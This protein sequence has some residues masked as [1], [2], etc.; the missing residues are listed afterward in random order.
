[1]Y[2]NKAVATKMESCVKQSHI[3]VTHLHP[4][5]KLLE[6]KGGAAC[7][8]GF[9]SFLT[10]VIGWGFSTEPADFKSEIELIE[11]FYKTA[12]HFRVD[13]EIS[14]YVGHHLPIFLSQRGYKIT[15]L[16]N[17]S[18]LDLDDYCSKPLDT[19]HL[20]IREIKSSEIDEWAKRVAIG[21]GFP[22]AREQFALYVMAKGVTAF[23]VFD[24]DNI[25]A[26]A[27]IAMHGDICDL[28]VTSTLPIYRGQ[29][30]QKQLAITRLNYAKQQGM[31]LATVTTEPGSIS[32]INLQKIGFRCAYTRTKLT[33]SLK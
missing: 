4:N 28:G 7:F 24:K 8:S 31:S 22:E 32:D 6:I 30:L 25:V 12:N 18:C 13:I 29:G 27:T 5:G 15:E 16:N 23:A 14:P 20:H 9:D 1:M 26:G 10:Q 2:I 21:F 19:D 17:V 33:L 3:E 11:Q